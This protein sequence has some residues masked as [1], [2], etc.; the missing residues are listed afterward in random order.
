MAEAPRTPAASGRS[1]FLL[2]AAY[3]ALSAII[4]VLGIQVGRDLAE[5]HPAQEEQVVQQ[6]APARPPADS[7]PRPADKSFYDKYREQL[8]NRVEGG[9]E[10]PMDATAAAAAP[11]AATAATAARTQTAARA[12]ATATRRVEP[13]RTPTRVRHTPTVRPTATVR[14]T[15]QAGRG[16]WVVQIGSTRSETEAFNWTMRLRGKGFSPHTDESPSG[17]TTWFRVRLGPF[18]TRE[19]AVRAYQRLTGSTEFQ[20]A[21]I[22]TTK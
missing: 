2:A 12:T 13:T 4:F 20:D 7:V 16:A 15:A 5:R 1:R 17:G 9:E 22:T 10:P 14:K 6:A 19:E 11:T 21:Y 3:V 8:Y 18:A